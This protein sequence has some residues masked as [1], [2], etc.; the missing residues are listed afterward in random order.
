[1]TI[2]TFFRNAPLAVSIPPVIGAAVSVAGFVAAI[3]LLSDNKED[4]VGQAAG[5]AFLCLGVNYFL[6]MN[7]VMT[8]MVKSQNFVLNNNIA[9]SAIC[10]AV[11]PIF[12]LLITYPVP[13]TV[14]W[15]TLLTGTTYTFIQKI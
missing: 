3:R 4:K 7:I 8:N 10:A 1:M 11:K 14:L 12:A 15:L 13:M 6:G 5:V 2:S 9:L